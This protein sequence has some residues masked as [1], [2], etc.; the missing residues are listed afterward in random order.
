MTSADDAVRE[1]TLMLAFLTSWHERN[2]A[3]PRAWKSYDFDALDSLVEQDLI[4][5]SRTAKSLY[6]TP[7]G[8]TRA[9]ELLAKYGIE[10]DE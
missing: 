3:M 8:E 6:I 1:L 7:E 10:F 5:H 9:R 2:E 4:E